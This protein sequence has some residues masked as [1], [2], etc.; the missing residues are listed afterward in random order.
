MLLI[1][2]G[3]SPLTR[4][5]PG[6][7]P[8][9]HFVPGLI[10][11]HAGKTSTPTSKPLARRAHPRSR[12]ENVGDFHPGRSVW[13]SSPLTRGKHGA[14]ISVVGDIGLIPA[15]A[16]KTALAASPSGSWRAHPRSRGENTA[17]FFGC[18]DT[19][20]SSP[21]TRGKRRSRPPRVGPGGLIPAHAGKTGTVEV[22]SWL[23]GAHPRSRGE[24][25]LFL[26][27]KDDTPGSSPLTR[28]KRP[29]QHAAGAPHG[30]IPAHAGKTASGRARAA[31]SGA[32]PRSRGE[33][34][35][36]DG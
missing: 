16:G 25:D 12:G 24:N 23:D 9:R 35:S 33:N 34:F 29:R 2:A 13:G 21:L 18:A 3:S 4:G 31:Y 5:K 15:H 7:V 17:S 6:W 36:M 19:L 11:A 27:S 26:V 20:G 14:P 28:G 32:H 30:L 22:A 10:P 1:A 8:N